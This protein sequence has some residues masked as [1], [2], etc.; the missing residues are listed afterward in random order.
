MNQAAEAAFGQD[1]LVTIGL[2]PSFPHTGLGY[3]HIEQS[4]SGEQSTKVLKVKEFKEKPDLATAEGFL[5]S[6]DYFCNTGMYTWSAASFLKACEKYALKIFEGV[7]KIQSAWGQG[8]EKKVIDEVYAN[9]EDI[10]IDYAVSEKADNL[11]LLPASFS[12]NDVGD[13]Q[14]V[15]EFSAKDEKNNSFVKLGQTGE[16]INVDSSNNLIQY[17]DKLIALVGVKDLVIIDTPDALLVCSKDQ[18]QGVK[19]I[20]EALKEKDKKEYL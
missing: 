13:W 5:K 4:I 7:K 1:Q 3:I 20:V 15:A 16:I 12:W 9:A 2:K 8:N 6:G 11:V 17:T 18:S 19:K 10:S 14:A